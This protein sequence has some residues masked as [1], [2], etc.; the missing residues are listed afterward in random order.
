MN[1]SLT[2]LAAGALVMSVTTGCVD[3]AA[4][5]QAKRTAAVLNNDVVPV[6]VVSPTVETL[7]E[8]IEVTGDVTA[9][10][11]TNVAAKQPG[12][13]VA[14]YVKDGDPVTAGQLLATLDSTQAQAQLNQAQAQISTALAAANQALAQRRQAQ[15]AVQQAQR[16]AASKP[17]Q[18]LAQVR[19]AEAALRSARAQ[20]QKALAGARPE[21]RRQAEANVNSARTNLETQERELKRVETL[22]REGAIAGNRLD[23]QRAA[24]ATARTQFE[25]ATEALNLIR[26]GTRTEDIEVARAAVRQAEEG[27]ATAR[28]AKELDP[29]LQDQVETA[30]AQV[31]A[32]VAQYESAQAQLQAA[33]AQVAI[34]R[35]ALAD[36]RITAPFS[37]KVAGRPVQAGTIAGAQTTI[38]RIIGGAGIYFTG[39]L[40]SSEVNRIRAGMPVQVSVDGLGGRRFPGKVAAVSALGQSVGRLFDVRIAL[41]ATDPQLRPGMFARGVITVRTVPG[42]TTLPRTAIVTRDDEK[43]VFVVDGDKAKRIVVTTGLDKGDRTQVMGLPAG[44]QV[45]SAGQQSLQEGAKVKIE[46]PAGEPG[47]AERR[48]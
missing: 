44:A 6:S 22:V 46:T 33:R 42:A 43:Y 40:P 41:S 19:Q 48:P 11:D 17:D 38:V 27:V 7:S 25:N 12:R 4:Q 30:R 34:A 36:T 23:Q 18:S 1:R 8:T 14:V 37:G 20:L 13:V 9:G 35:E 21:E 24:T 32:T 29:L 26:N 3:R 15:S 47:G 39:Q 2:F 10:E 5:E 31:Q 28:S 45:V 16:N